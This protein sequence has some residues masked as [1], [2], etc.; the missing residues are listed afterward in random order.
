M[1]ALESLGFTTRRVAGRADRRAGAGRRRRPRGSRS[2][3]GA[4]AGAR[5][6]RAR[7]RCST[8]A[9]SWSSRTSARSRSTS[10]RPRPSRTRSRRTHA[11]GRAPP[12]RPAVAAARRPPTI[13]DLPPRPDRRA[14]RRRS[15]RS[16]GASSRRA[17]STRWRSPT[18]STSTR[19]PGD[20]DE[21][22]AALGFAPT[23][24]SCCSP[25]GRSPARTCPAALRFA[26]ELARARG[27]ATRAR[28]GSPARPRTATRPTLDRAPRRGAG[29]VTV[30]LGPSPADAYAAADVVVFPSTVEGFGNPVIESVIARRPLVVGHYPV[31]D[32]ILA[33][34][35]ELFAVD[36]PEAVAKWLAD[37]DPGAARPQRRPRPRALRARRPPGAGSTPR[38]ATTDGR[39]G[40]RRPGSADP[41]R[42][43]RRS[44]PDRQARRRSAS[45]SATSGCSSRS[46]GSSSASSPGSRP[47]PSGSRS[48]GLVVGI[49]VLPLPIIFGYGIMAA[50]REERGGGRFH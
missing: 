37:P 12:S 2:T 18:P 22:R 41:D 42:P 8:P 49:V 31:L 7:S 13:T 48:P 3:A 32:E 9:T 29:P 39:A 34:G 25:R 24:S 38:S 21:T 27:A 5:C 40:E 15:T 1:R 14:A 30:G 16:P 36:E 44:A 4:D 43:V 23:S 45:A 10:T 6:R 28:S 46:S 19:P 17:A 50:E 20:R 33:H 47:G 11:R 35:F 26:E